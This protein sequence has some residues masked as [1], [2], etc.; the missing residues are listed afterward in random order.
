MVIIG[1]SSGGEGW[2]LGQGGWRS[3]VGWNMVRKERCRRLS[4]WSFAHGMIALLPFSSR[5]R[6]DS[7]ECAFLRPGVG[8]N[9]WLGWVG[10]S[11]RVGR[12]S[13][14][15]SAWESSQSPHFSSGSNSGWC[16]ICCSV[17]RSPRCQGWASNSSEKKILGQ[18]YSEVLSRSVE[19][20]CCGV[21]WF[22][23]RNLLIR[24]ELR[25]RR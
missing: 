6:K 22:C 14:L 4:S 16:G 25:Y 7:E 19:D 12:T 23:W 21:V 3:I 24:R 8:D 10:Y 13:F 20:H 9:V 11:Q 5:A 18:I 1:M 2:G 15:L 17:G